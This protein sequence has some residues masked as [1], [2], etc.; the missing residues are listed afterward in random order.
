MRIVS[1]FQ[2]DSLLSHPHLRCRAEALS[3]CGSKGFVIWTLRGAD[4]WLTKL[5]CFSDGGTLGLLN[6]SDTRRVDPFTFGQSGFGSGLK[7][8]DTG[9]R[10]PGASC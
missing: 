2:A 8:D 5:L 6:D 1:V 3:C 10:L 4:A 9:S 7:I